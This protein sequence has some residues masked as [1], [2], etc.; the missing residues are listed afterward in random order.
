[1]D[2]RNISLL[3]PLELIVEEHELQAH[4]S[5]RTR[6]VKGEK[7]LVPPPGASLVISPSATIAGGS[8]SK[9]FC[10]NIKLC[11]QTNK[12]LK[13]KKGLSKYSGSFFPNIYL[14]QHYTTE[15]KLK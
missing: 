14:H 11:F 12:N 3:S 8:V 4:T 13:D 1:M 10:Y 2:T 15:E 9:I 7:S 6:N 5:Q